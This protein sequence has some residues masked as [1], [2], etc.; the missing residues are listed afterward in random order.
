VIND[1]HDSDDGQEIQLAV[2][3]VTMLVPM[4]MMVVVM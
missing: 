2:V 3:I 1:T 4:A